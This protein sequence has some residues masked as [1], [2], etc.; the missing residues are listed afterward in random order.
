MGCPVAASLGAAPGDVRKL[1]FGE[2]LRLTVM[3]LAIGFGLALIATRLLRAMLFGV[4]PLDPYTF[5]AIATLLGI[6]ALVAC[7]MPVRRATHTDPMEA[8]RNE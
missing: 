4:S 3:G 5:A 8:L 2:G 1:I 6:T 7:A